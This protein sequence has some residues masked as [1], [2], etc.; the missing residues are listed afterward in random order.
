MEPV[1]KATVALPRK[2]PRE[3][4]VKALG[5]WEG[6]G[7]RATHHTRGETRAGRPAHCLCRDV[8]KLEQKCSTCNAV[9]AGGKVPRG[10]ELKFL[11]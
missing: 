4:K 5:R 9:A 2:R 10:G 6:G 7:G 11:F 1:D 3:E 8:M